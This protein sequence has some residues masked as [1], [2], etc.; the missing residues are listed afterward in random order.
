MSKVVHMNAHHIFVLPFS[1]DLQSLSLMGGCA[2]ARFITLSKKSS[3][4]IIYDY[5]KV[6][7]RKL[8]NLD[9]IDVF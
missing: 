5:C 2:L 6:M 8:W 9:E 3:L 7:E 4:F 1:N